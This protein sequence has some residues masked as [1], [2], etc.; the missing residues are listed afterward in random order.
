MVSAAETTPP[1]AETSR[2]EYRLETVTDTLIDRIDDLLEAD[3]EPLLTTTPTSIRI[4]ELAAR[5]ESLE[6]AVREI[7]LELQR[8]ASA[9]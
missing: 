4:R 2:E 7:A 8:L 6:K 5:N 3:R 1:S 9:E